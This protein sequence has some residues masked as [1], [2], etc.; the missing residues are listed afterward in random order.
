MLG[1]LGAGGVH[2]PPRPPLNSPLGQEYP[3]S[4]VAEEAEV[5][6]ASAIQVNLWLRD[7]CSHRQCD[8]DPPIKLR[9]PGV[10]ISIDESLFSNKP[11]LCNYYL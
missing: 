11:K 2:R 7:V 8:N 1:R 10:V 4:I 6:E 9:G 5:T 3:V